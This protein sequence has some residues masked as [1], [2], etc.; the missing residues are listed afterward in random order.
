MHPY[1]F[2]ADQLEEFSSFEE[3]LQ[4]LLMEAKADGAFTDFPDKMVAFLAANRIL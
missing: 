4:V 3:M 2:R 1:T